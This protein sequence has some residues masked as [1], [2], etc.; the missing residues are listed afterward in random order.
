MNIYLDRVNKDDKDILYRLLEYSLFEESL[1]DG[2]EMNNE[3]LFEYKDF[4]EYFTNNN[5][6]A[7]FIKEQNTNK[8]LGFIMMNNSKVHNIV[9]FMIIPKYRRNKIG[10]IAAHN[11]FNMYK[12]DWQITPSFGSKQAYQFWKKVIEKYNN[13]SKFINESFIFN[14][15]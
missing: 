14:N 4:N 11:C 13:N 6:E 2:N 7:F 12:G 8:L 1:Y 10:E 5:K 15:E 9:E 3:G